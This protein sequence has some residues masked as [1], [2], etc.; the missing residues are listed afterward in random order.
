MIVISKDWLKK[1][2]LQGAVFLFWINWTDGLLRRVA[3]GS[4]LASCGGGG[5]TYSGSD[6]K[7]TNTLSSHDLF[8]AREACEVIFGWEA[9]GW[10][11]SYLF[12][13]RSR[14]P[15]LRW[16]FCFRRPHA[17]PPSQR[18]RFV[19]I[20]THV[21]HGPERIEATNAWAWFGVEVDRGETGWMTTRTTTPGV[22][23]QEEQAI[24][25]IFFRGIGIPCSWAS[26]WATFCRSQKSCTTNIFK[27]RFKMGIIYNT[28]SN[29]CSIVAKVVS[30]GYGFFL[31]IK[32]FGAKLVW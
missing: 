30:S 28:V 15:F 18:N 24:V 25:F 9:A 8:D 11:S 2:V 1:A 4:T 21:L 6:W 19:I 16:T 10:C 23:E 17:E 32:I 22:G 26:L 20:A 13:R 27:N 5:A 7:P 31:K 12:A 29:K 3:V 14:Y